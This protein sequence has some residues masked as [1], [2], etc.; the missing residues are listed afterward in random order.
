MCDIVVYN[1]VTFELMFPVFL[2]SNMFSFFNPTVLGLII[3][4]RKI[5]HVLISRHFLYGFPLYVN[6]TNSLANVQCCT[7]Q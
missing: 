7:F 1:V 3:V 5:R 6:M 2:S 4:L